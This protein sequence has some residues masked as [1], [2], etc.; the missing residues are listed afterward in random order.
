MTD[1]I[2]DNLSLTVINDN[3][4]DQCGTTYKERCELFLD[5]DLPEGEKAAQVLDWVISANTWMI[6][7]GYESATML[8]LFDQAAKVTEYYSDHVKELVV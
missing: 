4:G 7:R 2:N 1:T 5:D 8:E 3:L 6:I